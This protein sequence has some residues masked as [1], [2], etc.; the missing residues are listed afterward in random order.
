MENN[1]AF[2]LINDDKLSFFTATNGSYQQITSSA[3]N[4]LLAELKGMLHR[5]F[6]R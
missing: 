3:R 6:F 2:M 4:S 5:Y 1:K